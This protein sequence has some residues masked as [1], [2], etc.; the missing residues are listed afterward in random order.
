MKNL[1][2]STCL[3]CFSSSLVRD[4]M[5][6]LS[7]TRTGI[8]YIPLYIFLYNLSNLYQDLPLYTRSNYVS[9]EH[10]SS[11]VSPYQDDEVSQLNVL[12]LYMV[13]YLL[14]KQHSRLLT[15]S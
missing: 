9:E 5:L 14:Y 8:L 15:H 12:L 4:T 7:V 13:S 3:V 6:A 11:F 10:D 1:N 2:I